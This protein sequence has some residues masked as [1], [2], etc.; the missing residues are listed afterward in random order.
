MDIQIHGGQDINL[1]INLISD[2]SITTSIDGLNKKAAN[3]LKSDLSIIEHYPNQDFK[4]YQDNMKNFIFRDNIPN[5]NIILGNGASEL[6]DLLI[7]SLDCSSWRQ[8][9]SKIQY[10]EYER[11]C[12]LTNKIKRMSTDN[13]TDLLCLVNPNNPTGDYISLD[14]LQ[15]YIIA[16]CSD[17]SS[18]IIDESMQPWLGKNW[19]ED[20]L[21]SK[22]AWIRNMA[23]Q[24]KINIFII[25]SWTKFFSCT[26]LRIGSLICPTNETYQ[27][28]LNIK[29]PWSVNNIALK[30]I[31]FC[32]QDNEYIEDIWNS[33][34]SQRMVQINE[35]K[36]IF[37]DWEYYGAPFLSWI[38]IDTK[39]DILANLC[40]EICKYRGV[41]IRLGKNGYQQNSYIRIAVRKNKYFE[42]LLNCFK[43]VKKWTTYQQLNLEEKNNNIVKNKYILPHLNINENIIQEFKYVSIDDIKIH[44][45]Y[46]KQR[47][48]NLLNYVDNLDKKIN[49][50]AIVI[51]HKTYT[52]IDGH[53]RLSIFRHF[54]KKTI[55]C[56]LIDYDNED[57]IVHPD[58]KITK[59][60]VIDSATSGKLLDPKSTCHTVKD[61]NNFFHP[62]IVISP[63]VFVDINIP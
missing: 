11:C 36:K 48:D 9:P 55:P 1:K 44:E 39:C 15:E 16:N 8:G 14:K 19:R 41:P 5:E 57:I 45:K 13:S 61:S 34:S 12:C 26:G 38:W 32:I 33:T 21:V 29:I 2:F 35:L 43:D 54:E 60:N 10:L 4:P 63:N 42:I 53:H 58:N 28:I 62:I 50:P 52:V 3:Y 46:I 17:N 25:H 40:Y 31:D 20:S 27:K 23:E 30:Y 37:P 24:K 18:V 6:I 51:C 22:T 56:I 49:V 47:H 59:Q 7:R